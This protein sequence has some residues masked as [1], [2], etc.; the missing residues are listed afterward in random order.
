MM[1]FLSLSKNMGWFKIGDKLRWRRFWPWHSIWKRRVFLSK[2]LKSS[3]L[4]E[5][6]CDVEHPLHTRIKRITLGMRLRIKPSERGYDYTWP[7][8]ELILQRSI[9]ITTFGISRNTLNATETKLCSPYLETIQRASPRVSYGSGS[10][11]GASDWSHGF[12]WVILW[13]HK[14]QA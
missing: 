9:C 5:I 2:E 10:P 13:S 7:Q 12:S 3:S 6:G 11:P 4:G 14:R 1:P 8:T